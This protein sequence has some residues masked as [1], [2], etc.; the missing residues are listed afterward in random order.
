MDDLF[1]A[2][3][4][5]DT[6]GDMD[7]YQDEEEEIA[8]EDAWIVIDKYFFEKGL[9]RQQLDSFDEFLFRTIQELIDDAGEI[10][11]TPEDQFVVGQDVEKYAY[12]VKFGQVYLS[13]PAIT[14]P[15]G[16]SVPLYPME[17]RLR[18]LTYAA[19]VSVDVTNSQYE[20]DENGKFDKNGR[21][22]FTPKTLSQIPLCTLPMMVRT[23]QCFLSGISDSE[24]TERG[25]CVY[26]QGGYFIINGSEKVI[27]AQERMSNNHVYVFKKQQPHKFEWVCETRSHISTGARPTSTMYLQMYGAGNK[28]ILR[29]PYIY[30][31]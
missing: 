18:N 30:D 8:Q 29:K 19:L 5:D 16:E 10:T 28:G 1:G 4:V 12:V 23:K 24:I 20:L 2:A 26:D 21:T 25:E 3:V 11:V 17:A 14:E 6:N 27:I 15:D 31:L 9:V 7:V 13:P 22:V